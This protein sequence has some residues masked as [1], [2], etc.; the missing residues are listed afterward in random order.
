M[1]RL[2]MLKGI[3]F[4]GLRGSYPKEDCPSQQRGKGWMVREG[5]IG[6]VSRGS[7]EVEAYGGGRTRI[8]QYEEP[9]KPLRQSKQLDLEYQKGVSW[10]GSR[11]ETSKGNVGRGIETRE[12]LNA[13]FCYNCGEPGHFAKFCPH[14][15]KGK[16][17]AVCGSL[18]HRAEMCAQRINTDSKLMT[19]RTWPC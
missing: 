10:G 2:E 6:H 13:R 8:T 19:V 14:K 15:A 12:P 1:G 9:G 3:G 17:C 4:E 5:G 18:A 11:V 16:G 7:R